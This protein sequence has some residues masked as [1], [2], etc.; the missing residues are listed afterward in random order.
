ME[1]L[2]DIL[3][4]K[5][6]RKLGNGSAALVK[7]EIDSLYDK[8]DELFGSGSMPECRHAIARISQTAR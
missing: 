4:K 7:K 6:F 3:S 1:A 2:D 8:L 5:V